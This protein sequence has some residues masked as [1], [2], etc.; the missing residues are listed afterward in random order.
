MVFRISCGF[1]FFFADPKGISHVFDV[2]LVITNF[3]V[4]FQRSNEAVT[5]ECFELPE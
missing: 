3:V 1:F 2:L 5:D 4:K